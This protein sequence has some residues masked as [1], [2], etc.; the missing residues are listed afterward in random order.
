MRTA[1]VLLLALASCDRI[2]DSD[3]D[4]G[5]WE[6][7]DLTEDTQ[8]DTDTGPTC[9]DDDKDGVTTCDGDCDDDDETRFPG[10][11]EVCDGVDNDCDEI[12]E[13][14]SDDGDGLECAACGEAGFFTALV[15]RADDAEVAQIIADH[16]GG[17]S[18]DYGYTKEWMFV[19]LDNHNSTVEGVYTGIAVAV[20]GEEPDPL[21]MNTEHTWPQSLG[22]GDGFAKCDT[23]HLFPT[24]ASANEVRSN[25]PMGEV[26]SNVQWADGGSQLGSDSAGNLVFEPRD[27]HKGNAA[28]AL[29]YFAMTYGHILSTAERDLY[30]SW[31]HLDPPDDTEQARQA[32]IA[33]WLGREN[34]LVACPFTIELVYP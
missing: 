20:A 23:H 9:D 13:W 26:V 6:L 33:D 28:R 31:H 16:T 15:S 14:E 7:P 22:G 1:V 24:L 4:T 12:T 29:L 30:V 27:A 25:H 17:I 2:P 5:D 21:V 32:A 18:C 10:N 11:P 34:A 3:A 8:N 19:E